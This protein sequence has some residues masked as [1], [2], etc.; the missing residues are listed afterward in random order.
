MPGPFY[1]DVSKAW[2]LEQVEQSVQRYAL[3]RGGQPEE[4]VGAA[5]FLASDA[6]SFTTGAILRADGGIP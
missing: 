1:T 3:R 2:D 6:S 5:L 4:I